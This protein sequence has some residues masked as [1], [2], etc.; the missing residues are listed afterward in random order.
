MKISQYNTL[1]LGISISVSSEHKVHKIT[2][3][4]T[5]GLGTSISVSSEHKV[6]LYLNPVCCIG[7]SSCI[8]CSELTLI[9]VPKPSVLYWDLVYLV[10]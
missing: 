6:H 2:Q 5:L 1:G 9:L 3:Y 7:R 4:N 10:F 8:L